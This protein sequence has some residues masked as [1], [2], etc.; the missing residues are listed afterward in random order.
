MAVF[1]F[2]LGG[3]PPLAGFV[4]KFYL[5]AAAIRHEHYFLATAGI[6][7]SVVSLYYYTRVVRTMFLDFPEGGEGTI[8]VDWYNAS[9]LALLAALTVVLGLYW[10]P[11]IAFANY[12]ARFFPG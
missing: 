11:V 6:L 3:I 10:S 8:R 2:S 1:L 7:N 12:S 5:F 4:G 9:L